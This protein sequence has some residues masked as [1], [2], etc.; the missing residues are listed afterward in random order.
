MHFLI[1]LFIGA[2]RDNVMGFE[3][4]KIA[5]PNHRNFN[6]P[7]KLTK[8]YYFPD[9]KKVLR[10]KIISDENLENPFRV[11]KDATKKEHK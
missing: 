6:T 8:L 7:S 5:F 4:L 10:H 11:V 2:S 1:R 3:L 9:P